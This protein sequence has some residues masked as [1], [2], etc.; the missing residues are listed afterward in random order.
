MS[1]QTLPAH[2]PNRAS[3]REI[4]S[5]AATMQDA[6]QSRSR[7]VRENIRR[8]YAL[9]HDRQRELQTALDRFRTRQAELAFGG[10]PR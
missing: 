10:P 1:A 8:Q 6:L 4:H 7:V 5:R 2:R 3:R 9:L